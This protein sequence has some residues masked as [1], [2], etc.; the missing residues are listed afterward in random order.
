MPSSHDLADIAVV[1]VAALLCGLVLT[2]LRQ[3]AIVGYII[4]GII[5]GPSG[6]SLVEDREQVQLLA[7]LGV[8]MLLFL[9]GMQLSLR[10][11]R[12]MWKIALL[13]AMLPLALSVAFTL[14]ASRL[15]GWPIE[16]AVLLGFVISLSST[17]VAIKMLEDIH[18]LHTEVGRRTVGILIAQDLAVV[19]ML[20]ILDG[21]GGPGGFAVINLLP[22][23]V[24]IGLLALLIW[25]FGKRNRL[26]MPFAKWVAGGPD[27]IPLTALTLCFA[28]AAVSGE[29]GLSTAYGAF[30]AGLL[31]G[32]TTARRRLISTTEP[33][34]AVLMMVFA[35]SIGLLIDLGFI[36][37][38]LGTVILLLLFV[39]VAKTAMNI[40]VLR[41]IGEP[42]PRAFLTGTVLAQVGE[43]SFVL[44]AAGAASGLIDSE[45]GR[46][47]VT[48]IAL[49]L[50]VSPFWFHIARRLH[51]ITAGGVSDGDQV[52]RV[53]Y[54]GDV[55]RLR[56]RSE[57]VRRFTGRMTDALSRE[58]SRMLGARFGQR[59]PSA[60]IKPA[61]SP[62]DEMIPAVSPASETTMPTPEPELS[63][64]PPRKPATLD[65]P[66]AE[67]E[68]S[69]AA[70]KQ[71]H[72]KPRQKTRKKQSATS[73]STAKKPRLSK[74]KATR[75]RPANT[76][77]G[78]RAG[79]TPPENDD[80]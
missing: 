60:P 57:R 32:R 55:R 5:L 52:L 76:S 44:A 16:L 22:I 41:L 4:A 45:G 69:A 46:L 24:A 80:A 70:P 43:F 65:L 26:E 34:Q 71:A 13:G 49:S 14:A 11:F 1:T 37:T 59:R 42:W 28:A 62:D 33:I 56:V 75:A 66:V 18:E 29:L 21:L 51:R 40:A 9:V 63:P 35:L 6:F 2:R 3:P 39:V 15:F 53:L 77:A 7:E 17:V 58:G 12:S 19:P 36:W 30:I 72:A 27:L 20:L 31:L 8:L 38:H 79:R 74:P 68:T 10:A 78:R 23:A 48:V 61:A 64:S 73:K 67:P 54:D 50:I 47:A 25:Y